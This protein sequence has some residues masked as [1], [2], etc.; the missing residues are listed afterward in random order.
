MNNTLSDLG[1]LLTIISAIGILLLICELCYRIGI[2]TVK[3]RIVIPIGVGLVIMFI[4]GAIGYVT[5]KEELEENL[6][7]TEVDCN[8]CC[9][10]CGYDIEA[11]LEHFH[12]IYGA[13]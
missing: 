8:C 11:F 5:F 10:E 13:A 9:P 7:N 3:W 4:L 6:L 12:S 2:S 1:M